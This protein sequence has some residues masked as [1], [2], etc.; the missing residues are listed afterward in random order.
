[1][2]E[3]PPPIRS[4]ERR[5]AILLTLVMLLPLA[6]SA[7]FIYAPRS[8]PT[9]H[10]QATPEGKSIQPISDGRLVIII[11][12]SLRR[13]AVDEVMPHL[14]AFAQDRGSICLD[15]HTASGNMSFPCIQTLLEG[16]E[17]PYASA[18]QDFTGGRGSSNS[19]PATAARAGL[20]PAFIADFIILGLYGQYAAI[21]VN[22]PQLG[23][24]ELAR[25][26]A[27]ID[28]AIDVLSDKSV[29]LII[30][31]VGGTDSVAHRW[32]P[33]HHCSYCRW[34]S[35]CLGARTW[36]ARVAG[37]VLRYRDVRVAERRF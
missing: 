21:T 16:R 6:L 23:T 29:R 4:A 33:G 25:D 19:L 17:S 36:V 15:V 35:D 37:G 34:N 26:L 22:S 27:G 7:F 13:Q 28:K 12:D 8:S 24:S 3:P 5:R 2:M 14:K 11:V 30:L 32:H 1:M 9:S 10:R 20:K 18:I 31:H